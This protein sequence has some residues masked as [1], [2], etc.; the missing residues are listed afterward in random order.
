MV[1]FQPVI[2]WSGSKRSQCDEILEYFPQC[3]DTYYEPFCG[4]CS[5]LMGL[6][7]SNIPVKRYVC[8]DI[9]GDLISL[10]NKVKDFPDEIYETY[11]T[12]W[13][14]L[15]RD[16]NI[17][18]KRKFFEEQREIYNRTHDPLVFFFIMRTTTNGM[19]RYNR[20]GEF[21]NG[22][23]ITRDGIKPEMLKPVLYEWSEK[24]RKHNVEFIHRSY[25]EIIGEV[26]EGDFIY[27]D[28]PYFNT[29]GMYFG[30][31][32]FVYFFGFLENVSKKNVKFILSFDGKSGDVDNT[33][34]VPENCY[35]KHLYIKSGNSSFKRTIG[36]NK[37]AIVYESLYLSYMPE[38]D[39]SLW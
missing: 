29:K 6:I 24:L 11:E 20:K 15:N 32:D 35:K 36:K 4:G 1:K 9:N 39:S 33:Y 13:K 38:N 18:R 31:I 27:M 30:G 19:P 26:K 2:K 17:D 3:I 37:N 8:S 28:P 14:E 10:W 25:E 5:M 16:D 12:L 7:N 34:S 23:H 21:N 22:F